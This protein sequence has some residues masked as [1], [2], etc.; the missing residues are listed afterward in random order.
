VKSHNYFKKTRSH[1]GLTIEQASEDTKIRKLWLN[2][3]EM[4]EFDKLPGRVY[5]IGFSRTYA[6]Y[7]GLDPS[8]IVKNV[9]NIY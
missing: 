5:A 1:A 6:T 3:M 9:T 7:L 8:F 2:Y 4:G